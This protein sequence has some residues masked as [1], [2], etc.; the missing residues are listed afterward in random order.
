MLDLDA[1]KVHFRREVGTNLGSGLDRDLPAAR[2][3][4]AALAGLAI[5]EHPTQDHVFVSMV[6][7]IPDAD[8]DVL[9]GMFSS[10]CYY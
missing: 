2:A 10:L 1:V 6:A 3:A 9:D 5:A 4:M 8:R 7:Q